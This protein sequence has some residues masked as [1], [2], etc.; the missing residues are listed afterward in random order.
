MDTADTMHILPDELLEQGECRLESKSEIVDTDV[1]YQ[2]DEI[3][4]KLH[5]EE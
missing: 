5:S 3:K 1:D 2:F 4:K